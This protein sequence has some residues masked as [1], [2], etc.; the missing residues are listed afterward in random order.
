MENKK[1]TNSTPANESYIQ[2]NKFEI[3]NNTSIR[4]VLSSVETDVV[5]ELDISKMIGKEEK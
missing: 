2:S 5:K 3:N 4:H 1:N